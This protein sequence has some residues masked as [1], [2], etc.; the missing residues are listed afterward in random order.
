MEVPLGFYTQALQTKQSLDDFLERF[1]FRCMN[2]LKLEELD[3]HDDPSFVIQAIFSYIKTGNYCDQKM[4]IREEQIRTSAEAQVH[5]RI[6]GL[7]AILYFWILKR[8]RNAVRN[9]ENLR[10]ARTK[11]FGLARRI[12]RGMGHAFT[13]LQVLET[14][15]DIFYLTLDEILAYIEGRSVT[16]NLGALVATRKAEYSQFRATAN[17][18]DRLLTAGAVG[19]T[20]SFPHVLLE[21]DLI[22]QEATSIR[23]S[24]EDPHFLLGT[25]CCPGV[26]EGVVRVVHCAADA[27]SMNGEILVAARTDPGWVPLFPSCSGL[28]VERG[29]L[30]SHSAVVARELGLPTI[31]GISGG[32]MQR[33][34]TGDKVSMDAG[35]GEV[36]ILR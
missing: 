9:R 36:R 21:S 12:F 22:A 3:L 19:L 18:P 30:L 33:L 11:I 14:E 29:S 6:S 34:K 27:G 5:A 17:P 16:L 8:A 13:Q 32:L 15:Q 10:F 24:A 7:K 20:C 26:V 23:D 1:G 35:K 25:P 2:E 31:V 4:Q 28:L